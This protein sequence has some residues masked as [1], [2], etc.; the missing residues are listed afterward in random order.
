MA[1]IPKDLEINL[2][3][4][5][6]TLI[7][8]I[9]LNKEMQLLLKKMRYDLDDCKGLISPYRKR[10]GIEYSSLLSVV[11]ETYHQLRLQDND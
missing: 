5:L 6:A 9:E 1:S 3:E 4:D 7:K 2:G 11:L 8:A 10:Y